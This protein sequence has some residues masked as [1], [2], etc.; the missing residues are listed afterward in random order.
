[1]DIIISGLMISFPVLDLIPLIFGILAVVFLLILL[2]FIVLVFAFKKSKNSVH[3]SPEIASLNKKPE[4]R[5]GS[6]SSS[7]ISKL[8]LLAA[9]PS[10]TEDAP[11]PTPRIQ[12]PSRE[13]QLQ[14]PVTPTS[15]Q[16]Q[17]RGHHRL[18]HL[19]H[20]HKPSRLS[21]AP[22]PPPLPL[23]PSMMNNGNDIRS[24]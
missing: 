4:S 16:R 24:S 13:A 22:Q 3:P 12:A 17:P 23:A 21:L 8:A 10:K 19:P 15:K 2:I 5:S 20:P 14:P 6:C 1:M 9:E 18:S 7:S 11:L